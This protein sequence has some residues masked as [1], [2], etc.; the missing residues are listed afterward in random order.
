MMKKSLGNAF[1]AAALASIISM[2]ASAQ[3]M[4]ASLVNLYATGS[5][6]DVKY[7][8]YEAAFTNT[9]FANFVN[10]VNFVDAGDGAIFRNRAYGG[11]AASAAGDEVTLNRDWTIG[12]EVVFSI[13]VRRTWAPVETPTY[14][15]GAGSRNRDGAVHVRFFEGTEAGWIGVGFEDLDEDWDNVDSD[16]ND[17]A[18]E[19]KGVS[20]SVVPEPMTVTLLLTG[21]A[22]VG[23]FA[24]RRR[25]QG[26]DI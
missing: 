14:F 25:N 5:K 24:R 1:F 12:E 19:V 18:F 3:W 16:F 26:L 22:G 9:V 20:T 8:G 17:V 10:G 6:I 2:P 21:L 13:L 4:D 7:V 15:S 11:D 23:I